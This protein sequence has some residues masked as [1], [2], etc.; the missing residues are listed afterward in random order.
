MRFLRILIYEKGMK[1]E[2]VRQGKTRGENDESLELCSNTDREEAFS[3][4]IALLEAEE[5]IPHGSCY[6]SEICVNLVLC[7]VTLH[8]RCKVFKDGSI[9]SSQL[10]FS[11]QTTKTKR[12]VTLE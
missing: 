10:L 6:T 1:Y 7:V 5:D 8:E 11:S 12:K 4:H 9:D 2:E 3:N